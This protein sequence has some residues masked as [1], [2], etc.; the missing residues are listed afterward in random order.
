[1]VDFTHPP[2]KTDLAGRRFVH[3]EVVFSLQLLLKRGY[4]HYFETVAEYNEA[5]FDLFHALGYP[6][7]KLTCVRPPGEPVPVDTSRPPYLPAVG[8]GLPPATR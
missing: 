7:Q 8:T 6:A 1:L 4:D 3:Q 2:R 5:Q